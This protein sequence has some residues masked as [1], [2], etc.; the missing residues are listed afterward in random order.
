MKKNVEWK[1]LIGLNQLYE[2]GRTNLRIENNSFI[3]QVLMRQKKLIKPKMGNPKILEAKYGYKDYYKEEFLSYFEYY[4]KFFEKAGLESNAHKTY[5]EDDLKS[6]AFIYYQKDQLKKNLTTEYTFSTRVFKGKGAKYLTNKPSL[7]NAVLQLLE[8]DE[9][10]EKDPKNAQWRFVVD[11]EDPKLVVICENIACLKVPYEYKQNNIELWY[12]GG[13]NTN[14][15]KDISAKKIEL[16]LFYFCDWDHHGLSIYSRIKGIFQEKGKEIRL[17]EPTT[18][19]NA[20]PVD[21]PHHN[22]KWRKKEFSGLKK[23]NFSVQQQDIINNLI[24]D[25]IWVEEESMDLLELLGMKSL[26]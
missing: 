9:F 1:Y 16:P 18:L 20:L 10:P 5:N 3:K 23:E 6:L 8:I 7:R 13:N 12:V 24:Q 22:S 11:C 19:D 15:L 2:K 4:S 25:N 21:S 26:N 17:V 14:P